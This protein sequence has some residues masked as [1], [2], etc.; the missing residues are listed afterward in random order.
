MR[1]HCEKFLPPAKKFQADEDI[2]DTCTPILQRCMNEREESRGKK[3]RLPSFRFSPCR[4]TTRRIRFRILPDTLPKAKSCLRA[5]CT[6]R[7]YTRRCKCSARSLG[8]CRRESEKA[9]H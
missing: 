7:E 3:D 6:K 9:R 5:I 2:P 4:K 1:K 8:L